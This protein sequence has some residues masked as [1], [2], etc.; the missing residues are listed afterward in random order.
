M[1]RSLR[2]GKLLDEWVVQEDSFRGVCRS[3]GLSEVVLC[4]KESSC[5]CVAYHSEESGVHGRECICMH[6]IGSLLITKILEGMD[7]H[8][9]VAMFMSMIQNECMNIIRSTI[10]LIPL[11]SFTS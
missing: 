1:K 3:A 5:I 7:Q 10:I 4:S 9:L 11:S 2:Y 6:G 8:G